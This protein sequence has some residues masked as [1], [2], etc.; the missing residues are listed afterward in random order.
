VLNHFPLPLGSTPSSRSSWSEE[1]SGNRIIIGKLNLV[2]LAVSERLCK[3]PS[4]HTSSLSP[5]RRAECPDL[6]NMETLLVPGVVIDIR[7]E[8]PLNTQSLSKKAEGTSVVALQ[9]STPRSGDS[10]F[11]DQLLEEIAQDK[12]LNFRVEIMKR[13]PQSI[14]EPSLQGIKIRILRMATERKKN[15]P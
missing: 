7:K 10:F 13:H 12:D 2:D 11:K 5:K 9:H 15:I 8:I 1:V 14:R 6:L 4:S 3:A